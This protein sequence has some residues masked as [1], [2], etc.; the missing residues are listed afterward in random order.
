MKQLK[1]SLLYY[2]LVFLGYVVFLFVPAFRTGLFAAILMVAIIIEVGLDLIKSEK[3]SD[4]ISL[5][6]ISV[7]VYF[8]YNFFSFIFILK[9]G[10]PIS[11]Y[12]EEFSNSILPAVFYF[13]VVTVYNIKN[14]EGRLSIDTFY[15][16]FLYS[17]AV[18]NV[19]C[20]VLYITAPQFY[21][22][23]L[24][25]MSLISKADA[26]T[27][28]V[29]MEGLTGS[30][31]IGYLGVASMLVAAR[32]MYLSFEK[33]ISD[34]KSF[35]LREMDA[36]QKKEFTSFLLYTFLFL[37]NLVVVFMANGRAGMVCALLVIVYI[38]FLVF[39]AFKYADRK[40]LYYEIAACV[41]LIVIMC[42]AVPDVA[43]KIWARLISLPGAIGQRSEQWVAAINNMYGQ[44]FGNGLGANGHKA[45]H[46]EGAHVIPDGGLVKLYCEE[47]ALGFSLFVYIMIVTFRNGI[48]D[49]KNCFCELGIIGTALLISIG[50]NVI[51]F[52]PC[53]P[54]FWFAVGVVALSSG[55]NFRKQKK[56]DICE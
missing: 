11:V 28:Q 55:A 37:F 24:F 9:N 51:A 39:I 56:E 30:T 1:P 43:Y 5:M 21:C 54:I 36:D 41:I 48:K 26:Q 35:K 20:I 42:I 29:R 27:V 32:F 25:N 14:E 33:L 46:V 3:A 15:K 2:S 23:Y 34:S 6:N 19:I 53:M 17:Y 31:H 4:F 49:I 13:A 10:F 16:L 38:N 45:L 47:G 7:L 50:S 40:Y 44:W 8:V 18:L 22:D 52:Q 12:V